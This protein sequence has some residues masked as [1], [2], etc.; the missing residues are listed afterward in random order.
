MN[1]DWLAS[2]ARLELEISLLETRF[3]LRD[4]IHFFSILKTS[5]INVQ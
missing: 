2:C 1:I 4:V 3:E 5:K